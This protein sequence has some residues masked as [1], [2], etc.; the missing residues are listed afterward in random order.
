[1]IRRNRDSRNPAARPSQLRAGNPSM[2]P[3]GVG[4][5]KG[6]FSRSSFPKTGCT[7]R[8]A[9]SLDASHDGMGLNRI[10]IGNHPPTKKAFKNAKKE[11]TPK[12]A[13]EDLAEDY[14]A[15]LQAG[16]HAVRDLVVVSNEPAELAGKP[17]FSRPSQ[18]SGSGIDRLAPQWSP[19]N[20][21]H[22]A[23]QR[24]DAGKPS[25]RRPFITLSAGSAS[26]AAVANS[27]TLSPPSK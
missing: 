1:M 3:S 18:V 16:P 7:T 6:G 24:S 10:S 9:H 8:P 25:R 19:W 5:R 4:P 20:R 12:S 17:A 23:G 27:I 22:R 2:H 14:I 13:P 21:R 26:S 15:E 11:S